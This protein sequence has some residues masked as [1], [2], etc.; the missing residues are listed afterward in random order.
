MTLAFFFFFFC[1]LA[2]ERFHLFFF[3]KGETGPSFCHRGEVGV[4]SR[5]GLLR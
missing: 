2:S 1:E 4:P 3:W 5:I